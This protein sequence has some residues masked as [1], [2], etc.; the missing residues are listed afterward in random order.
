MRRSERKKLYK[1]NNK[2]K[3]GHLYSDVPIFFVPPNKHNE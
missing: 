1:N 3:W 2:P